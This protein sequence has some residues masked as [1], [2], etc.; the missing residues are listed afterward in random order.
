[1]PRKDFREIGKVYASNGGNLRDAM[2]AGG[3]TES[4]AARGWASMGSKGKDI[5]LKEYAS[6]IKRNNQ[7]AIRLSESMPTKDLIAA[8]RGAL[9]RNL[10]ERTDKGIQSIKAVA[11]LAETAMIKSENQ[12]GVIIIQAV[13]LPSFAGI[14]RKLPDGSYGPQGGNHMNIVTEKLDA[15]Q[16]NI[17]NAIAELGNVENVDDLTAVHPLI[18]AL[19]ECHGGIDA[20]RITLYQVAK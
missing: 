14:P 18:Q 19:R 8:T 17:Y 1:M 12:T 20:L 7:H 13:N 10:G 11:S 6:A 2:L 16:R 5:V 9:I 4:S 15:A 3:Y